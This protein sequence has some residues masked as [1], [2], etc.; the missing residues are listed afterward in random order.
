MEFC[1]HFQLF[2]LYEFENFDHFSTLD[3]F[4]GEKKMDKFSEYGM[5]PNLQLH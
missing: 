1:G 5:Q 2:K 4:N 3:V